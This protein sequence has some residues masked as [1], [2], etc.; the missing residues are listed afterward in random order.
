MP[1]QS[2]PADKQAFMRPQQAPITNPNNIAA[3]YSNQFGVSATMTDFTIYFFEMG[4][5]PG[6]DGASQVIK[7]MVTLP[8][9]AV[10]G[11]QQVLGQ[12]SQQ[13][14][15]MTKAAREAAARGKQ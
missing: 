11:L 15:G 8:L 4:Q 1:T 12:L 9:A 5:V 2:Q 6:M 10:D 3:V 7:A 14:E 13:I